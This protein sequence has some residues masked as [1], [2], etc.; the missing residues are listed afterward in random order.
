MNAPDTI[1]LF[2]DMSLLLCIFQVLIFSP[3][4]TLLG[5]LI[6]V[7]HLLPLSIVSHGFNRRNKYYSLFKTHFSFQM[8]ISGDDRF[9]SIINGWEFW[10]LWYICCLSFHM[11]FNRL[12]QWSSILAM[13]LTDSSFI[14]GTDWYLCIIIYGIDGPCFNFWLVLV[15]Q[16]FYISI[17]F[18]QI[19]VI[20]F[21]L[22]TSKI[23]PFLRYLIVEVYKTFPNL[24]KT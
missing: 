18:L 7:S 10:F 23:Y 22:F 11:D 17:L 24:F 19:V 6:F 13:P 3:C 8:H 20:Y 4:L 5:I 12:S 15:L 21:N 9:I 1:L 14:S 2:P 16:F